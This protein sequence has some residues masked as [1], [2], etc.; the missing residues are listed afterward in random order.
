MMS[1][2]KSIFALPALLTLSLLSFGAPS[3]AQNTKAAGDDMV[4]I[5]AEE[6]LEWHQDQQLY[7]A[8]GDA[9]AI[10]DGLTIEADLLTAHQRD[11][12]DGN[13]KAQKQGANDLDLLTATGKVY[14]HDPAQKVYG[15][16]ALYNMD[17]GVITITGSNL[18]YITKSDIVTAKKSLEYYEKKKIAVARG[19]AIAEH[20]GTRIKGNTLTAYFTQA[21]TGDLE[22]K[23]IHAKDNVIIVTKGGEVSR[24]Q[25]AVYNAKRDEA[26]LSGNVRI[27]RGKTQLSGDRAAIN[28][29][30][31][32]SRLLNEGS[33]RVRVLLPSSGKNK[34]APK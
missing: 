17:K 29:A 12:E 7:I 18:K 16:K 2:M 15:D 6:S 1:H 14:I 11:K 4:D 31:G 9:K 22:I 10:K 23:E 28:F 25:K 13:G 34:K 26:I 3:Y 32:Q 27:T 8:R 33:G 19:N 20:E 5:S 30:T 24:G 21:S